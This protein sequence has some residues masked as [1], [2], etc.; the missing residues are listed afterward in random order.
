MGGASATGENF[1][2]P[3]DIVTSTLNAALVKASLK[4][5]RLAVLGFLAGSYISFG[6]VLA[7][8][9]TGGMG[10]S[11]AGT[12]RLVSG[13][14]FPVGLL[15]VL[16][17]GGELFTGEQGET[18]SP[19]ERQ[20]ARTGHDYNPTVRRSESQAHESLRRDQMC[21]TDKESTPQKI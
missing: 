13:A 17:A 5:Q 7:E 11:S 6:G 10:E 3:K 12:K 8:I 14:I 20:T 9:V 21:M 18:Q 15:C 1:K 2:T 4:W 16:I 19:S